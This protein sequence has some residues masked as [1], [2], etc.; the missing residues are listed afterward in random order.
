MKNVQVT[1]NPTDIKSLSF[2]NTF[3]QKPGERIELKVKSEAAIKLNPTNPVAAVVLIKVNVEDAVGH[4]I[5]MQIETITSVVVSTFIDE[6]DQYIKA[7]YLP[8]IMMAAN[9]KIRAVSSLVGMPIKIPNPRFG[10]SD[11]AVAEGNGL[12]Q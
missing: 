1:I 2:N 8:V 7:N 5:D 4:T 6:L 10:N 9:E 12:L 11:N 3:A